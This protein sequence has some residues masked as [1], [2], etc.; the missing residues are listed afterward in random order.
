MPPGLP[1][2]GPETD[3]RHKTLCVLTPTRIRLHVAVTVF[4]MF[5]AGVGMIRRGAALSHGAIDGSRWLGMCF[6]VVERVD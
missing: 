5:P 1:R 4:T 2:K 6:R 3:R